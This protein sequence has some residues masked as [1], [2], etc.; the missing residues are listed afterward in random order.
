MKTIK[1][2]WQKLIVSIFVVIIV[3]VTIFPTFS[4]ADLGMGTLG[5]PI[6]DLVVRIWG[7]YYK[8]YTR[9]MFT[10]IS[11]SCFKSYYGRFA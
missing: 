9:N 1:S 2:K 3:S 11:N 8:F 5:D 4:H 7:F 10:R 6:K